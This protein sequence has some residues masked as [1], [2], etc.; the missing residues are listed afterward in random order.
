[1]QGREVAHTI[2]YDTKAYE[3]T[4]SDSGDRAYETLELGSYTSKLRK[5]NILKNEPSEIKKSL[6]KKRLRKMHER[7]NRSGK[8]TGSV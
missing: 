3:G 2:C 1:Q 4:R 6:D 5:S 8:R 7:L